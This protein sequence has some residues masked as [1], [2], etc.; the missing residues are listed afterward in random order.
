MASKKYI[1]C[2]NKIV[3][4]ILQEATELSINT[5]GNK[6][7]QV[8]LFGS[9]A[10]NKQNDESD[11]DYMI[12]LSEKTDT[13]KFIDEVYSDFSLDILNKYSELPSVIIVNKSEFNNDSDDFF[14]AVQREGVMYYG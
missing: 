9:C 5:F 1:S 3:D 6:L 4:A 2:G 12:V 11:I 8:W 7:C 10:K 14:L 13:W